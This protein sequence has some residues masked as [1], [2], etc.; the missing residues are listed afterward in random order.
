MKHEV[1]HTFGLLNVTHS[2]I[3]NTTTIMAG[4][5]NEI[6]AC[7]TEAIRR[8]YCPMP[9]PTP[10]PTPTPPEEGC[11]SVPDWQQYPT[12]G[13]SWGFIVGG[14]G[15]GRSQ[16]YMDY[17]NNYGGGYDWETCDCPYNFGACSP[18]DG[19]C[20][21]GQVWDD[22]ICD[23][24]PNPSPIVIDILG[25]GFNLTNSL[26]G[27]NFDLDS[28]GLPEK[29]SWTSPNSDDAWLALD[30]N[31]NGTIDDGTELFGN[32][33]AQPVPAFGME[34]NGF[35]ALAEFDKPEN[36]GNGDGLIKLGDAVFGNLRLW[37]DVNHNGISESNELFTLPQ[38]GL[39]KMHLDYEE[40]NEVDGFGNRFKYRAK[41]KDSNDV[42]LGR[43]AWDVFLRTHPTNG[44]QRSVLIPQSRPY[45]PVR[46]S[47]RSAKSL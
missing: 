29:L 3:T 31:G 38:L 10:T 8:I 23:C 45:Y 26:N 20:Q 13:C 17:C 7:D 16:H 47:C 39:R 18:P 43:W 21:N 19:G 24:G 4:P 46:S 30:R 37:Q 41:V 6:R 25:N 22:Q 32:F 14:S 9:T 44:S 36:G 15:C 34:K 35:S 5:Y 27:V 1:G 2:E 40:S 28:D 12:T 33:T 11:L 42:Q